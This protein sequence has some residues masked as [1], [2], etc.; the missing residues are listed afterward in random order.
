MA[1]KRCECK[2]EYQDE[3]YG[4][5]NRVHNPTL[6]QVGNQPVYRCTVC[7]KERT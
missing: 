1:I 5:G 6:K 3:V 2:H 4:K 7:K